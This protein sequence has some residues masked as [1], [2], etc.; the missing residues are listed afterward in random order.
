M[1]N[2]AFFNKLGQKSYKKINWSIF[3]CKI[4]IR[5]P[6]Q[7]A[8][9]AKPHN[10]KIVISGLLR[11]ESIASRLKQTQDFCQSIETDTGFGLFYRIY[12]KLNNSS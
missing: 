1:K 10:P 6:F 3:T 12:K 2:K 5:Y 4:L 11:V 8:E 9:S 7:A